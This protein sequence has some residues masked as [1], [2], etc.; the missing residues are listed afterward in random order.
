MA[1]KKKSVA[2]AKKR[3]YSG[4]KKKTARKKNTLNKS[5]KKPMQ[6]L[7]VTIG[8]IIIPYAGAMIESV[9]TKSIAPASSAIMNKDNAIKAAKGAAVGFIAGTVAGT[10]ADKAGLKRPINKVKRTLKSLTGGLI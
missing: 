10:V 1:T 3:S 9:K 5:V 4:G 7:G 2:A 8:G 6:A